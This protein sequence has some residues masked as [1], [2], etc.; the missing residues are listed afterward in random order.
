MLQKQ[1]KDIV[2]PAD[3]SF[4]ASRSSSFGNPGYVSY[5]NIILNNGNGLDR[6]TGIF[7][8]PKSGTYLFTFHGQMNPQTYQHLE[9]VLN[10]MQRTKIENS[11]NTKGNSS[12]RTSAMSIILPLNSNDKVGINLTSGVVMTS[13]FSG[14]LIRGNK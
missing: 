13:H 7:T 14:F 3:I 12:F 8:A 9:L 5:E 1:L 11:S 2:T 10:G 6:T 4:Y